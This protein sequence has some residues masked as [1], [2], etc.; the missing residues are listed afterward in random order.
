MDYT[1][2]ILD[3]YLQDLLAAL[4]AVAVD[5]PKGV[6][7]TATASRLAASVI[8]LDDEAEVQALRE[9]PDRLHQ[10]PHPLLIDEW[11][12]YPPVWDRVR[13]TVDS[14]HQP[15]LF[16]LTGSATPT[17]APKHSG[18]ARIVHVRMR[19]FSLV[20]RGLA[21]PQV[22][23]ADLMSGDRLPLSA[24]TTISVTDYADEI[25]SGGLPALR[26]VSPRFRARAWDGY[27]TEILDRDFTELGR[28][29]RRPAMLRAWLRSYA[30][31]TATTASYTDILDNATVGDT[32]KP[33]KATTLAWR[34]ILH[35]MWLLDPVAAWDDPRHHLS[36]LG[37]M[38]KHHLADPAIAAHLLGLTPST[39]LTTPRLGAPSVP[40]PGTIFGALFESL[41][42]LSVRVY[43]EIC[44]ATV[45][46]LRTKNGDHEVDLI[47]TRQDGKALAIEVKS[48][49][50]VGAK[51]VA[52]LRWLQEELGDDL[53]DAVVVTTGNSA[54][55]RSS[56]NIAVIPAVLL[57]P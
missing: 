45:T 3:D 56:D 4:P 20:E 10:L 32:D 36:R 43:A 49:P 15:G 13:R 51:D 30:G 1:L 44:D 55:R 40:Q 31:A 29:V 24:S 47:L 7:K 9:N 26:P 25:V 57:G 5:G 46:H 28:A 48:A 50:D 12:F 38:P 27:L 52:H 41:V 54:Y 34:E 33:S 14:N 53:L 8:E 37:Q 19:P 23:L 16:I 22:S 17:D 35:R 21:E 11:Q 2:R 39:L 6:G 42:T 18:A